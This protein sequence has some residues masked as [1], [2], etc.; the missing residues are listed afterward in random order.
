MR[1]QCVRGACPESGAIVLED[2]ASDE[3]TFEISNLPAVV[4]SEIHKP[5]CEHCKAE[6]TCGIVIRRRLH[7][8]DGQGE[9]SGDSKDADRALQK[10]QAQTV[11]N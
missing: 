8:L 4:H 2:T 9:P 3:Q 5:D 1:M 7:E 6:L 10:V 11:Q